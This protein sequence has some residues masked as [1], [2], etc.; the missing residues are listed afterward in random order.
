M[1][2]TS[3]W[4][5]FAYMTGDAEGVNDEH[6]R[7]SEWQIQDVV[8]WCVHRGYDNVYLSRDPVAKTRFQKRSVPPQVRHHG[9]RVVEGSNSEPGGAAA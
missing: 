4:S 1:S 7:I 5:V 8:R 2:D 3:V 9:I 6:R